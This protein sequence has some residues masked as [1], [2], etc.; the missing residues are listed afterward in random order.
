M[1]AMANAGPDTNGSQFFL[2]YQDSPL[3][4]NYTILGRISEQSMPVLH[5]IAEKGAAGGARDAT[6]AEEVRIDKATAL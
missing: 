2:V 3:P 5:A 4:P 1:I 6:P